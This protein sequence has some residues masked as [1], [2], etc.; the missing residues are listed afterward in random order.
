[1]LKVVKESWYFVQP[2]VD[3]PKDDPVPLNKD[4]TLLLLD[5]DETRGSFTLYK[6]YEKDRYENPRYDT[7]GF[8]MYLK[9][10]Q[11]GKILDFDI[12]DSIKQTEKDF[13]RRENQNG[14]TIKGFIKNIYKNEAKE[15]FKPYWEKYIRNKTWNEVLLS[16]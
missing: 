6:E 12:Y 11:D 5:R 13:V 2:F 8:E 16:C 4:R 10:S 15:I 9:L 3:G 7:Y 1:M 14:V